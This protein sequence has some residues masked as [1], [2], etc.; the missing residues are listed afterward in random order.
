MR[1]Y[2][3]RFKTILLL[4][5]T[6]TIIS[7]PAFSADKIDSK[8]RFND[9]YGEV[10]IRPNSEDD[11]AYEYAELDTV[12]YEDDRIRTKEDSGAILGLEDMSTYVIKPETT[13]I[14]HTEEGNV[15]K[16]E[17]LAGNMWGNIKKMAEGKSLE[18]EMSQCVA[19][20]NGTTIIAEE[21]GSESKFSVTK[22][23][24]TVTSKINGIEVIVEEG[25]TVIMDNK[26]NVL[27]KEIDPEIQKTFQEE[28]DK[29]NDKLDINTIK[30]KIEEQIK[31]I[32]E[33]N[34]KL[35]SAFNNMKSDAG[36]KTN[37]ELKELLPNY[38]N[39]LL[40]GKRFIGIYE[41]VNSSI[42]SYSSRDGLNKQQITERSNCIKKA[43]E[44]MDRLS[45]TISSV[46]SF[47]AELSK[48]IEDASKINDETNTGTQPD[49][50]SDDR[51]EIL[52][53]INEINEEV[54]KIIREVG[55]QSSY[56]E[57]DNAVTN[58]KSLYSDLVK[59]GERVNTLSES[60]EKTKLVKFYN[61][62]DRALQKA[63]Q[64]FSSVPEIESATMNQMNDF[65]EKIPSYASSIREHLEK[66]K[67]ISNSTDA[68]KQR[69]VEAV[70]RTLASYDR[71]RRVYTKAEK[72]YNQINRKFSQ[73]AYKSSEYQEVYD[74]W[75]RISNAMN[76]LDDE[77]SELSSCVEDLKNQLEGQLGK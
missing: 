40:E 9:L 1:K 50:D 66:Y 24:S 55:E 53:D 37:D 73:A 49:A 32:D 39:S 35:N 65:D 15:S 18:I 41:E 63:L 13:L 47:I 68:T 11:D 19:G 14:I 38:E 57:F 69:Y 4:V 72:L 21:N 2:M 20:I 5:L 45:K 25:Q 6:L 29:S 27:R 43:K 34:N 62:L 70:T 42:K 51:T 16:I 10:S 44:S 48:K 56:Q 64:D 77:A 33:E 26:G 74:S 75:L 67:A 58:L 60:D 36:S 3:K 61:M 31:G 7:L 8:I 12:I 76:E 59:V 52:N 23:K 28:L 17:M 54:N 71:M 22:G 30:G 46:E